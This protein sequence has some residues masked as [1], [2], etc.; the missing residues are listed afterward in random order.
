MLARLQNEI[1]RMNAEI[2]GCADEAGKNGLTTHRNQLVDIRDRLLREF[3]RAELL[4]TS[5]P[6]D[7][8]PLHQ[9]VQAHLVP[10]GRLHAAEVKMALRSAGISF[11]RS[12]L[13]RALEACGIDT[14]YTPYYGCSML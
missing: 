4:L 5:K 7:T 14:S 9:W 3:N 10:G 12:Q 2:V 13:V 6:P 1:D 8:E 11:T